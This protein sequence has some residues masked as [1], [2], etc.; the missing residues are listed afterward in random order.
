MNRSSWKRAERAIAAILGGKRIPVTGR[1]GPDIAHPQLS[2]EVKSRTDLPQYLWE[3][4]AQAADGAEESKVP[5]V[6]L[7]RS[8]RVHAQDDLVV[9][10]IGEL[11]RLLEGL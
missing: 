6:V 3:W 1:K 8:G 9:M 7:H 10:R 4:L 2:V 5:V 11:L